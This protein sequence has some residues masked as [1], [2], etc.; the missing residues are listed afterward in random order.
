VPARPARQQVSLRIQ[1]PEQTPL[2]GVLIH[3]LD[4]QGEQVWSHETRQEQVSLEALD[5]QQ[6]YVLTLRHP[7]Y[8]P[9]RRYLQVSPQPQAIEILL[10]MHP[11]AER[12]SGQVLGPDGHALAEAVV[13]IADQTVLT[14]AEGHFELSLGQSKYPLQATQSR[15]AQIFRQGYQAW[16]GHLTG[17]ETQTLTLTAATQSQRLRLDDRFAPLGLQPTALASL[18][19]SALQDAQAQ[20]LEVLPWSLASLEPER[21]LLWLLSPSLPLDDTVQQELQ[22]FVRAGGKL[23]VNTEWA[24]FQH[25]EAVSSQRLLARFGLEA[26]LDS[27]R[28][29]HD[30]RLHVRHFSPHY[31]THNLQALQLSHSSSLH[32]YHPAQ[33]QALAFAAPGSFRILAKPLY[34]V[35]AVATQGLGKVVALGD[36]SLWLE[37]YAAADNRELWLRILSW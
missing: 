3:V 29:G 34:P 4:L 14:D 10:V 19:Q 17:G 33:G 13:Q 20:G 37:D 1:S 32:V 22:D 25:Y 30:T 18:W 24:G 12:F 11:R 27:L 21:D 9:V 26:G 8:L 7:D 35:L 31:L 16:Q 2:S 6:L 28:E 36:S 23:L 15:S 5:W